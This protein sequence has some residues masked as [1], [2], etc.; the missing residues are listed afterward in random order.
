MQ[1]CQCWLSSSMIFDLFVLVSVQ[2]WVNRIVIDAQCHAELQKHLMLLPVFCLWLVCTSMY[3]IGLRLLA[4][5]IRYYWSW[6]EKLLFTLAYSSLVLSVTVSRLASSC[7]WLSIVW[8]LVKKFIGTTL[9]PI[10]IRLTYVG[11][12]AVYL[13]HQWINSLAVWWNVWLCM[14]RIVHYLCSPHCSPHHNLVHH[15]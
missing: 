3:G 15:P 7:S 11:R 13:F 10:S 14:H 6:F 12:I 9:L 2:L 8:M 1:C 4:C 5:F